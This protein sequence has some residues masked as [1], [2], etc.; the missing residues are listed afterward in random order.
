MIIGGM[1][2]MQHFMLLLHILGGIRMGFYLLLPFL[3]L[4]LESITGA[5][6]VGYIRSLRMAN[7]YAG[8]LL[9]VQL[10]T[11]GYLIQQGKYAV[12]WMIAVLVLFLSMG[13]LTGI[14]RKHLRVAV[15]NFETG[16]D[17]RTEIS[18]IRK[19]SLF[20]FLVLI[21]IIILMVYP[22]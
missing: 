21:T 7:H 1:K 12:G 5:V 22:Q 15:R 16:H 18:K 17:S 11:G 20:P 3:C 9:F 2:K 13:P 8:L 6:Q 14:M 19:L 10:I 4:S